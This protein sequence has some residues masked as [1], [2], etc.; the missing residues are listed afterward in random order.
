MQLVGELFLQRLDGVDR[1]ARRPPE[2]MEPVRRGLEDVGQR[3][4]VFPRRDR[5]ECLRPVAIDFEEHVA[6]G[7]HG[8]A[9]AGTL[10]WGDSIQAQVD[11]PVQEVA[12][13][14]PRLEARV[15]DAHHGSDAL[16]GLAGLV[17]FQEHGDPVM[18]LVR[19][20]KKPEWGVTIDHDHSAH[21]PFVRTTRPRNVERSKL[22]QSTPEKSASM[23][24]AS[25]LPTLSRLPVQPRGDG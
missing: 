5:R 10:V 1:E 6:H 9:R 23:R 3:R 14:K 15:G 11:V 25:A 20:A 22:G 4:H 2:D 16:C 7:D 13:K 18:R 17:R 24:A 8:I 12:P 19:R 21:D